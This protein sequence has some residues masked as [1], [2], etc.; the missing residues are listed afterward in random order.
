[1]FEI[2]KSNGFL[3]TEEKQEKLKLFL[4]ILKEWNEK[5][6]LTSIKDDKEIEIKHFEDSLKGAFLFPENAN[7]IEI[8]SGGGFPSIPVMIEREDLKFTLVESVGKKCEFLKYAI[9]KLSL[10]A[11]VLNKRAEDLGKDKNYRESFEVVTARAV[12]NMQT[13]SEYTLPLIKKGGVFIA[14]KSVNN[15]MDLAKNAVKI[16]GGK[17]KKEYKYNLSNE[18]GERVIYV[19]EKIENTPDKYPR[20]N[21]KERS[22]PL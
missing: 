21:G 2:L 6:N 13:L 9:E 8:G 22:K 11:V 7:A 12:A 16:L 3:K 10:N 17:L 5:F 19:I 15:E 1:M 18:L 14:Y 20:G 4:N